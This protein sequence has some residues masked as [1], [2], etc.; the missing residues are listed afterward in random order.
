[1]TDPADRQ[2]LAERSQQESVNERLDRLERENA[3]LRRQVAGIYGGYNAHFD[4]IAF[5]KALTRAFLYIFI[6]VAIVVDVV[7]L[8]C[9]PVVPQWK[10]GQVPM[11]GPV[12]LVDFAGVGTSHPGLGFGLFA[13]GGAAVG[14]VAVGGCAIGVIAVG[15]GSFG[16]IALG[17]GSVGIIA[18]GGGAAG[19]I[20]IGG[21]AAGRY[22]LGQRAYGKAALGFNRQDAE[23]LEFFAR[24][25]PRLREALRELYCQQCGYDLTGNTTGRC[26]ECGSAISDEPTLNH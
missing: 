4:P 11:I 13:F 20:A 16:L 19:Y 26:P 10:Q 21:G 5:R 7:V 6:P 18:M 2:P 12:P 15:G 25:L 22:A 8:A 17:G 24:F 14:L 9:I 23:A 1:M 3:A